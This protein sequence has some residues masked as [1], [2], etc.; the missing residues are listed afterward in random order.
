MI[1]TSLCSAATVRAQTRICG[2]SGPTVA[3]PQHAVPESK[4]V[5]QVVD[6]LEQQVSQQPDRLGIVVGGLPATG[7]VHH[8]VDD[9][10]D[11]H[12]SAARAEQNGCQ[13]CDRPVVPANRRRQLQ[14]RRPQA[15]GGHRHDVPYLR[16]GALHALGDPATGEPGNE[17]RRQVTE[18]RAER[19][20]DPGRQRPPRDHQRRDLVRVANRQRG[21]RTAVKRLARNPIPQFGPMIMCHLGNRL[22][23]QPGT[24]FDQP[25]A[26]VD[27]FTRTAGSRRSQSISRK[28]AVRQMIA[29]LGT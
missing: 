5:G 17:K 14:G 2:L 24:G 18:A 9:R 13:Q 21:G 19:H 12:D 22:V 7:P 20:Q 10:S 11:Q 28:A 6:P 8:P 25:P 27:I 26:Q 1:S 29:A 4:T 3:L 23:A 15:A 16:L